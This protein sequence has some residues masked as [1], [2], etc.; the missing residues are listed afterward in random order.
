VDGMILSDLDSDDLMCLGIP[1]ECHRKLISKKILSYLQIPQ[2]K[3]VTK[4]D[5]ESQTQQPKWRNERGGEKSVLLVKEWL[6]ENA[7]YL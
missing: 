3:T 6:E 4:S 1:D 7:I 2:Q 5:R